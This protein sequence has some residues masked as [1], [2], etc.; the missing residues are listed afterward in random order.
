VSV[1]RTRG[2][3]RSMNSAPDTRRA[4]KRVKTSR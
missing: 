3:K 4:K 1:T 2:I